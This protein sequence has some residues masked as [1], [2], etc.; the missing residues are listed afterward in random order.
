MGCIYETESMNREKLIEILIEKKKRSV[1][2]KVPSTSDSLVLAEKKCKEVQEEFY[3]D[4][5][6]ESKLIKYLESLQSKENKEKFEYELLLYFDSLSPINKTKFTGI[7][8]FDSCIDIFKKIIKDLGLFRANEIKKSKYFKD[9]S[10]L[11]GRDK[12]LNSKDFS[13]KTKYSI[14]NEE[15]NYLNTANFINSFINNKRRQQKISLKNPELYFCSLLQSYF[16]SIEIASQYRLKEIGRIASSLYNPINSFLDRINQKEKFSDNEEKMIKILLFA[17]ILGD[18]KSDI[19][20]L[21]INFDKDYIDNNEICLKNSIN[22]KLI[23]KHIYHPLGEERK[24]ENSFII[25]KPNIYNISL[26]KKDLLGELSFLEKISKRDLIPYVKLEHFQE[27]NFYMHDNI[28]RQFNSILFKYILQS[29]TLRTLL[30]NFYPNKIYIFDKEEIINELFN[31]IIFVPFP[32]YEGYCATNKKDLSIFING[33]ISSFFSPIL[34]LSKSCSFIILGLH[35]GCSHWA[36]AYYSFL[37]QDNSLYRSIKFSKELL[38]D[39]GFVDKDDKDLEKKIIDLVKLDGGEILEIILF[40]RK[41][42]YFT[43]NEALFLLCRK[44]YDVDYKTFNKNYREVNSKD[45]FVLFQEVIKDANLINLMKSFNI[46]WNF[47]QELF[48][49]NK[50]NFSFKRNGEIISNSR[51]GNIIF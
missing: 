33:L 19:Y 22:D 30:S 31:S 25:E 3:R 9:L 40:G 7:N 26:L 39:I 18:N 12:L 42:Q 51:C 6:D 35:E 28:Y 43:L 34:Y 10:A 48:R 14:Q 8:G 41:L 1:L 4:I 13:F 49:E 32:I 44:S 16:S 15:K 5:N 20:R 24:I 50:L 29:N 46:D 38:I 37:Y 36:S 27:N 2:L 47:F 11:S 17:P 45:F 21:K 23:L